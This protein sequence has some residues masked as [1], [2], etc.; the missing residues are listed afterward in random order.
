MLTMSRRLLAP[1]AHHRGPEA[2]VKAQIRI[3][4]GPPV[5][6]ADTQG[7]LS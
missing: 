3:I 4:S 1:S 6:G 5:R 2:G 7:D